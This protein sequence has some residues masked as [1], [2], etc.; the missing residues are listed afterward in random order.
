MFLVIWYRKRVR[1]LRHPFA[2]VSTQCH[3]RRGDLAPLIT[4]IPSIPKVRQILEGITGSTLKRGPFVLHASPSLFFSLSATEACQYP[5]TMRS[6][7]PAAAP[8]A[9]RSGRL[10]VLYHASRMLIWSTL[11]WRLT[12][13]GWIACSMGRV[14]MCE[15][16][17]H[18]MQA[19]CR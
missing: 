9:S 4:Q 3:P 7:V 11:D 18:A 8:V 10:S 1:Q 15:R 5:Y 17:G 16:P 12:S 6:A 19:I 2:R 13:F 14:S